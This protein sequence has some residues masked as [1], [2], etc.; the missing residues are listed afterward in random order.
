MARVRRLAG[1][2]RVGHA[3]TL[4]PLAEGV[5]PVLLGRATRLADSIQSGRKT[6]V[7]EIQLGA[8]TETDDAEG[9]VTERRPVPDLAALDLE[10]TLAASPATS[11][12]RRPST[13]R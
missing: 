2:K 13:R 7:A 4:D 12:R 3:G 6:Y 5:L 10:A 11:S 1:Q 8:A 9:A